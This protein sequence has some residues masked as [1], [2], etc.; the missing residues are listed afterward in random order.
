MGPGIRSPNVFFWFCSLGK[1]SH[2]IVC[3][4]I[5]LGFCMGVLIGVFAQCFVAWPFLSHLWQKGIRK[6]LGR[7]SFT[8]QRFCLCPSVLQKKHT[9]P[10][11]SGVGLKNPWFMENDGRSGSAS[12]SQFS[13]D[14]ISGAGCCWK[15]KFAIVM[16]WQS[17]L[18]F[19]G[20]P[21]YVVLC[22]GF[23]LLLLLLLLLCCCCVRGIPNP[24]HGTKI[25]ICNVA[26]V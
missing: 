2:I 4:R 21:F 7:P 18:Q 14:S 8:G 25:P 16:V 5:L 20:D 17:V 22:R 11:L 23:L 3:L 13:S 9:S 26:P 6:S 12:N 15:L 1:Y 19:A 24:G 10:C